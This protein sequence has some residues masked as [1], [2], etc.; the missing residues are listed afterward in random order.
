MS[1]DPEP[2]GAAKG[3]SFGTDA[4]MGVAGGMDGDGGAERDGGVEGW[5]GLIGGWMGGSFVVTIGRCDARCSTSERIAIP[6][7]E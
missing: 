7:G 3:G 5:P 4:R 2:P 1:T 6:A